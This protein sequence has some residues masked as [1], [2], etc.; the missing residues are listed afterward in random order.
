[1]GIIA[2]INIEAFKIADSIASP[3]MNTA[4]HILTESFLLVLPLI[5]IYMLLKRDSNVFA[6]VAA[7]IL[8]YLVSDTIKFIVKEPRP[9][10]VAQFSWINSP[11]C[12]SSYSFPSNHASV[13]TGLTVFMN[14]YKYIRIAYII[15]LVAILFSRIYLGLH[16]FTDIIAGATISLII[17]YALYIYRKPITRLGLACLPFLKKWIKVE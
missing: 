4:M 16:Y 6:L 8:L 13:L 3:A 10:N 11:Y 17:S 1:M 2:Q 14:K 9:C 15:W 7:G 12:E 5:V